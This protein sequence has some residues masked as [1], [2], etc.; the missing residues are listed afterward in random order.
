MDSRRPPDPRIAQLRT[1]AENVLKPAGAAA[2]LLDIVARRPD[3]RLDNPT[4]DYLREQ[5]ALL[6][7]AVKAYAQALGPA[8][9]LA[10]LDDVLASIPPNANGKAA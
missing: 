6:L 4:Q 7:A 10:C 3:P 2:A 9:D 8:L 5:F 1:E